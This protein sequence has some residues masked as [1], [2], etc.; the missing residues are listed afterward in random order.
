MRTKISLI[1]FSI[2]IVSCSTTNQKPI[3]SFNGPSTFTSVPAELMAHPTSTSSPNATATITH[4][5]ARTPLPTLVDQDSFLDFISFTE[6]S[7][8]KFPCWV[9]VVPGK[10][11]FDDAIFALRPAETVAKLNIL[12]DQESSYGKVDTVSLYL[13]GGDFRSESK[14]LTGNNVN[15]I[16]MSFEAFTESTPSTILPLP[17][18]FSMQSILQEYGTPSSIFIYTYVDDR[19]TDHLSFKVLLVYAENQFYIE[20]HRFAKLTGSDI[21]A[22]ESEYYLELL[23][24][25][26]VDKLVSADAIANTPETKKLRIEDWRPVEQALNISPEEF[27]ETYS[28]SSPECMISPRNLWLP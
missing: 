1:L 11:T 12:R 8:C 25:D 15:L 17:R 21:V 13:Y 19:A 20:Y 28:A 14:F 26:S 9:G 22:C 10:T 4:L 24:E 5:S 6:N 18:R 16:R 23:V 2:F 3:N 7:I 27:H